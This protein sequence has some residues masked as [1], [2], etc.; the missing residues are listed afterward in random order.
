M[1]KY[2]KFN[3]IILLVVMLL[4]V[5]GLAKPIQVGAEVVKD[6]YF[7]DT[8]TLVDKDEEYTELETY[9]NTH[10]KYLKEQ[11]GAEIAVRIIPT[12]DGQS[13]EEYAN[14]MFRE[15][16]IGDKEKNNGLLVLVSQNDKKFRIEVGYGLEGAIPDAT[17]KRYLNKLSTQFKEGKYSE[18]LLEVYSSLEQDVYNEYQIEPCSGFNQD[19]VIKEETGISPVAYSIE[20]ALFIILLVLFIIA[21]LALLV[22][23]DGNSTYNG[24]SYSGGSSDSFGSSSSSFSDFGGGCSSD[25]F[26][27]FGGGCSGGGGASG[28]W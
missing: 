6:I 9:V 23:P 22:K 4:G 17:C 11:C 16:G 19:K 21:L 1:K 25:S 2:T 5:I 28:G 13:I 8:S 3:N 12:L 24:G 18:G 14:N 26:S 20:L 15:L 7:E 27:D 10:S